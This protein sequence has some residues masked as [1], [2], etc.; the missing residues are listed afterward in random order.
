VRAR[1]WNSRSGEWNSRS[2][3]CNLRSHQRDDALRT[4][5]RALRT[6]QHAF[7]ATRACVPVSGI[8]VLASGIRVRVS[9]IHVRVSG[10]HVR[11][12]ATVHRRTQLVFQAMHAYTP[13]TDDT[14]PVTRHRLA[15][16]WRT[17]TGTR[18]TF[19]ERRAV[20]VN[21]TWETRPLRL[22]TRRTGRLK[23]RNM[24][25]GSPE[26]PST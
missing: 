4:T 26:P 3:E 17:F 9:G 25:Y 18:R 21:V 2:C 5:Q 12:N 19:C 8:H 13:R 11:T 15:P 10:I 7:E 24:I 1:E 16:A 14:L 22:P 6:T 20:V 23:G